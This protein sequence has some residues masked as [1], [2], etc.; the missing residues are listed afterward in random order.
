MSI[1]A[2]RTTPTVAG[3]LAVQATSQALVLRPMTTVD[4]ELVARWHAD[5]FPGGFAARLGERYLQAWYRRFLSG[6]HATAWCADDADGGLAGY[7][8]GTV[9]EQQHHADLSV[10]LRLRLATIGATSLASRPRLWPRFVAVRVPW[11]GRRMVNR[12]RR[13]PSARKPGG[14]LHYLVTAPTCRE[15]GVGSLL[16][17][18]FVAIATAAGA[19]QLQLVTLADNFSAQ[20][21]YER[22]GWT[23]AA[24]KH[25]LDGIALEAYELQVQGL[26]P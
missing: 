10:A 4:L 20:Q 21:F 25:T 5:H 15:Q 23:T 11:H 3:A 18:Q 22:R 8:V 26:Q 12:L 24:R 7:I 1:Q 14:E 19:T 17:D 2:A 6:P 9:D 13:Q 16:H